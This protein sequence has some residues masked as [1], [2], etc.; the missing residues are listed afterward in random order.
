MR[1]VLD[2]PVDE[3][4]DF[5]LIELCS[6]HVINIKMRIIGFIEDI[7]NRFIPKTGRK[8]NTEEYEG[9][10]YLP[11]KTCSGGVPYFCIFPHYRLPQTRGTG[12]CTG[13]SNAPF[14]IWGKQFG[15][16]TIPY[17]D[18]ERVYV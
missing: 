12:A 5:V 8:N 1:T 4:N 10:W 16:S 7:D 2:D 3:L 18:P 17:P 6:R 13:R 11:E 15:R 14:F 9:S